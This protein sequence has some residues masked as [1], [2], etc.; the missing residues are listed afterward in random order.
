M[1]RKWDAR[2]AGVEVAQSAIEGLDNPPKFL[3][4][5]STIHYE[6]N[7]GFEEFLNGVWEIL[8]I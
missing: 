5:F 4:L 8:I 2:D 3:L 6:K 7:G 1:S